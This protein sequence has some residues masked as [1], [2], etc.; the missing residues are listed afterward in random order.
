MKEDL[1]SLGSD[2]NCE[3]GDLQRCEFDLWNN[4]ELYRIR[5]DQRSGVAPTWLFPQTYAGKDRCK[6]MTS[7][8]GTLSSYSDKVGTKKTFTLD[9]AVIECCARAGWDAPKEWQ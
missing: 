1:D 6:L 9:P 5:D 3:D 4:I 7:G 8:C 2:G